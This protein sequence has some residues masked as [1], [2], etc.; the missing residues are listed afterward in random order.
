[1]ENNGRA[2]VED[3]QLQ[4]ILGDFDEVFRADLPPGIQPKRRVD[5][6]TVIDPDTKTP[7]RG[8]Y[9]L[10]PNETNPYGPLLFVVKVLGKALRAVVDYRR[11]NTITKKNRTPIP[12]SHEM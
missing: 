3:K 11:L 6:E 9:Q 5:H 8:L 10:S 2:A 12:S 7:H 4:S 1:M